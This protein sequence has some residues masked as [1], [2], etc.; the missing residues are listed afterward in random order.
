MR[1]F[2]TGGTG[3]LGS[4]IADAA[5]DAGHAVRA[6]ARPTSDTRFLESVGAEIVSG[7]LADPASLRAGAEGC[8]VVI[9]A[10]A[11]V[12]DWGPWPS[13]YEETVTASRRVYDAAVAAGVP[14]G[15][16]VSSVAVYGKESVL[17]GAVDES[18]GP[19]P[20]NRLPQWYY[21]GRAKSL[22]ESL[23]MEYHQNQTLQMSVVRPAWIYG[24]RDRASLPRVLTMLEQGRVQCIGDG[25]N[26]L[27]LTYAANVA[28]AILLAATKDEALGEAYNVSNDGNITQ[29]RYMDAL[30]DMLGVPHVQKSIPY[31]AALAAAMLLETVHR[32][33][34]LK[35]RPF[36]TRQGV[37]LIA[38][39]S[40]FSTDKIR[41]RLGWTPR[42]DFATALERI[43]EWWA[44]EGPARRAVA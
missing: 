34:R 35:R 31:K 13:Y 19:V 39:P 1:I 28:D 36:V 15:V 26:I 5:A 23:A 40:T 18:M 30:A 44:A 4:Y 21:Y 24:P 2:L 12:M 7:D 10:A 33:L 20:E 6:L 42:V 9:H 16:H 27:S 41:D 14:R 11:K 8:D 3:F 17:R 29:R 43:A 38:L 25:S 37:Q 32:G 22:A